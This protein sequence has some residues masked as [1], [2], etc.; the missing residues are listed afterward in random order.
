MYRTRHLCVELLPELNQGISSNSDTTYVL[1]ETGDVAVKDHD[2]SPVS[3]KEDSI[4]VKHFIEVEFVEA[5][6]KRHSINTDSI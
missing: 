1:K 4:D 6:L 5:L 3:S 2:S